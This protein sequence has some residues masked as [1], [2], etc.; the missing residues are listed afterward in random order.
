MRLALVANVKSGRGLDPAWLAALL[1]G[2]EVF[3]LDEL[4]RIADVDRIVVSGGDGT[5]APVAERAGALGV[6]LAVIPGGTANDF[7]RANGIPSDPRRPRPRWPSRGTTLRS[8]E[9]GR[10]STGRPFV[11][12]AS[13]GLSRSRDAARSR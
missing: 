5:I 13:A 12:V 10:L 4:A 7:A 6:P 11:N 8:L 2:A 1:G 3:G 9:L